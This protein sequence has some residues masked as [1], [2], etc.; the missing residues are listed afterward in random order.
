MKRKLSYLV[1]LLIGVF[2]SHENRRHALLSLHEEVLEVQQSRL[3]H[4]L[5]RQKKKKKTASKLRMADTYVRMGVTSTELRRLNYGE[6][7]R[8]RR[9]RIPTKEQ[10]HVGT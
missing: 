8:T 3:V 4:H 2:E 5:L 7:N 9:I 10:T 1:H 6:K